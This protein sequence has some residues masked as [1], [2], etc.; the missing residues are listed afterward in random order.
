MASHT[1]L[2]DDAGY[3]LGNLVFLYMA[4]Y[5]PQPLSTQPLEQESQGFQESKN[6][7]SYKDFQGLEPKVRDHLISHIL[8]V[9]ASHRP[10]QVQEQ[11][12]DSTS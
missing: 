9:K 3:W 4:S 2:A 12:N 5:P 7:G 8:V 11:G 1:C 10:A 6:K